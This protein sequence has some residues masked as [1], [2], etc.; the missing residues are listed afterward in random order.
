MAPTGLTA[1]LLAAL[2]LFSCT[3]ASPILE[4]RSRPSKRAF[5]TPSLSVYWGQ[6]PGQQRLADFC[7]DTTIDV[8]PIGFVNVFPDQAGANNGYPATN[9]GNACGSPYWVAPDGTQ[10]EMFTSCWQI[11]EDIPVCQALGKKILVSIGGDSPGNFIAS[12]QSAK[13]FA[14]F[15]WGAY[16]PPQDTTQTLYPRP[17]GVD[18]VVD[19]F[20]LDIE[21]GGPFG[22]A[23][24]VTEL[25]SLFVGQ[26][27]QYYISS[28]PQCIVPDAHLADAIQN[29][30]FDYVFVQYYNTD[31]CSAAS[32]FTTGSLNTATDI[33]FGW[34]SWLQTYSKN[35]NVKLFVGLPASTDAAHSQDYLDLTEAKALIEAYACSSTYQSIFGGVMLW[36]ATYSANN[37]INGKSYAQNIKD[38][39][40][41]L[42]CAPVVTTTTSS[43]TT[44]TST[45][46]TTT[47]TEAPV[48]TTTTTT[49]AVPTTTTTTTTEAPVTTTTTTTEAPVT[50]TTTTTEAP[51]TTTTT[52]TTTTTVAV[53][54]TTTTPPYSFPTTSWTWTNSSTS[55]TTITTTTS[56]EVGPIGG[57]TSTSGSS[58]TISTTTSSNE[59]GP[60]GGS[61]TT[62][63][64]SPA[65]S[66]TSS[67]T[68]TSGN[69]V[70]PIGGSTTVSTSTST[71]TAIG[72]TWADWTTTS[73]SS[74][75]V[76]PISTS[77]STATTT[78]FA[79]ED[80]TTTTAPTTTSAPVTI[81]PDY[82]TTVWVTSY[83][84]I[85]PTGFTTLPF[86]LTTTITVTEAAPTATATPFVWPT[87]PNGVP[88]GFTTT[89]T[90]CS[91]CAET[92]TTVTLTIPIPT[93][94]AVQTHTVVPV[95][96]AQLSTKTGAITLTLTS[97]GSGTTETIVSAPAP[98]TISLE[99]VVAPV[100]TSSASASTTP[101]SNSGWLAPAAA[102]GS[103]S[104]PASPVSPA[105]YT[106]GAAPTELPGMVWSVAACVAVAVAGLLI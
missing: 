23:D 43:T 72:G 10:T 14:D 101:P 1:S 46:L 76:G 3:I 29:A 12:S 95:E 57:S 49:V 85:C 55:S 86:T 68:T 92:L 84:D 73:S 81:G 50:T 83:I 5:S 105:T 102:S 33:S 52:T 31:Q 60:I 90:V 93:A 54:T 74:A 34:A 63:T 42:S 75:V 62:S 78:P 30:E 37:Q 69:D 77:A 15:L 56:N 16:G 89:V 24:L 6:G 41:E 45:T 8:I 18:V 97:G 38:L 88:T 26:P 35:P 58:S 106:G 4:T 48:T 32:L 94:T 98:T 19:G 22:Y 87:G 71:S 103:G 61:T 100:A 53:P 66:T 9:Y 28:A 91:A 20:D 25:R 51:V 36:E 67:T 47:T 79:W 104:V 21:S 65:A 2:T 40:G 64:T 39:F 99:S 80:W 13:D 59:V 70:G 27:K 11:A 82:T 7:Q 17:F 44:V 96:A